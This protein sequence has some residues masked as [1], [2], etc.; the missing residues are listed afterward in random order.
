MTAYEFQDA[1]ALLGLNQ[2]AAAQVLYVDRKTINRWWRGRW[3]VG[4]LAAAY[5]RLL[6]ATKTKPILTR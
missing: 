3:P 4:D 5:L 1:L 6:I 2:S